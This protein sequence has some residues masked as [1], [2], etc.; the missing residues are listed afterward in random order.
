MIYTNVDRKSN[1]ILVRGYDDNGKRFSEKIRYR[2]SLFVEDPK[3]TEPYTTLIESRPLRKVKPG[4]LF[5]CSKFIKDYNDIGG[6][7]I[8]GMENYS[9]QWISEEFRGQ[10]LHRTKDL[11][12]GYFDI[13]AETSQGFASPENPTE[14]INAITLRFNDVRYVFGIGKFDLS[15][16]DTDENPLVDYE[17]VDESDL[18]T[19]FVEVWKHVD[20]DII[21]GWNI[22]GYDIPYLINR[23]ATVLGPDKAEE[24]SP[25]GR[26]VERKI[27][28]F[29]KEKQTYSITGVAI[30]DYQRLYKKYIL[31]PRESYRL[32]FIAQTELGSKKLEWQNKYSSMHDFYT[33]NFQLFMEYNVIDTDL[34]YQL[35]EKLNLI[36]LQV[37][38]AYMAKVNFEDVF[39]QVRTWDSIIYN[40]LI[41]KDIVIPLKKKNSKSVQYEGAFVKDPILGL[42]KWIVSF[43]LASLYPSLI[44]QNNMS[45]ETL[46]RNQ[47]VDGLTIDKLLSKEYDTKKLNVNASLAANGTLYTNEKR[48]MLPELM[49][50]LYQQRKSAKKEMLSCDNELEL[51]DHELR[52]RGLL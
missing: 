38:V 50:S 25:F 6:F 49:E 9:V 1:D 52:E 51:I 36:D 27:N 22:D 39:S 7:N 47:R 34:V 20:L 2:P 24:L 33:S 11:R 41:E 26:I 12:V 29:G 16:Y 10:E 31:A 43:D 42:K 48:G 23:I 32:D 15:S 45:P 44:M 4:T 14:R 35:E 46:I 3:S 19:K 21:T 5:D 17:C 28:W 18:L 8:H 40:H 30:L 37:S 13:E